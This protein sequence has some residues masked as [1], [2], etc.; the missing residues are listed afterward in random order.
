MRKISKHVTTKK[1][2][3]TKED[4]KRKKET[5]KSNKTE[6]NNMAIVSPFQ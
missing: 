6:N 4:S 3:E 5:P 1:V 2:N